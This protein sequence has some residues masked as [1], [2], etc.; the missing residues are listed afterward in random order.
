MGNSNCQGAAAKN[1]ARKP[2]E[3]L[4]LSVV[5]TTAWGLGDEEDIWQ[6]EVPGGSKVRDLKEKICELY[7]IVPEAQRLSLAAGTTEPAL[8]DDASTETLAGKRVYMNPVPMEEMLGLGAALGGLGGPGGPPMDEE[9][10]AAMAEMLMGTL[11]EAAEADQA[12]L[13][14]L[15]GV[16]YKVTFQRP[17]EAGGR[18]A[19]RE[20]QLE[21]DAL[22][23]MEL[24]QQLVEVELFGAVGAEPAHF[25]FEGMAVPPHATLYHAGIETGKVVIVSK[26]PPPA[27][28]DQLM[29]LLA[30]HNADAVGSMQ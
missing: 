19:G 6:V 24:V 10:Q 30:A 2:G 29:T 12:V 20:V 25:V 4:V 14:S 28:E 21:L 17:Q 9:A 15:Q 13:E 3:A 5:R 26:D 7:E 16:T 23:S 22:A 18:A 27:V 1:A 8:D 11:Q